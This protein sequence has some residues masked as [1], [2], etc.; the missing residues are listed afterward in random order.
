[1]VL[2]EDFV[3][4]CDNIFSAFCPMVLSA[5]GVEWEDHIIRSS[6]TKDSKKDNISYLRTTGL[7]VYTEHRTMKLNRVSAG[8]CSS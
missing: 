8:K 4:F 1:M 5:W 2:R 6:P 3:S 7:M